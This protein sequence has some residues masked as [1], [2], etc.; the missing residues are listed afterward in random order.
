MSDR[1]HHHVPGPARARQN[2]VDGKP[3]NSRSEKETESHEHGDQQVPRPDE[4]QVQHN[5]GH[6]QQDRR[7]RP[8]GGHSGENGADARPADKQGT[9]GSDDQ[10]LGH[11]PPRRA[12]FV[13]CGTEKPCVQS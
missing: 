12:A 4:Q 9:Y 2:R 11:Q 5:S 1:G 6:G 13:L 7:L 8:R 3:R 10:A